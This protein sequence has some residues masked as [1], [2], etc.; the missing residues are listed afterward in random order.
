MLEQS[1]TTSRFPS[2][3]LLCSWWLLFTFWSMK[4]H[5][6]N[7]WS[8]VLTQA[9]MQKTVIVRCS[10]DVSEEHT[11]PSTCLAYSTSVTSVKLPLWLVLSS[12]LAHCSIL[13]IVPCSPGTAQRHRNKEHSLLGKTFFITQLTVQRLHKQSLSHWNNWSTTMNGVF[14]AVRAEIL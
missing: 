9:N 4:S 2:A 11:S 5:W 12:F 10:P 6:S 1:Q 7:F 8:E 13:N 3:S 14:Y